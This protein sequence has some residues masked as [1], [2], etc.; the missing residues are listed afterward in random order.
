MSVNFILPDLTVTGLLTEV[1]GQFFQGAV[2]PT[3]EDM[4]YQLVLNADV[5]YLNQIFL[6]YSDNT[7]GAGE[8]LNDASFS[9]LKY[10]MHVNQWNPEIET[11]KSERKNVIAN[12]LVDIFGGASAASALFN[13]DVFS[14][15][16]ALDVDISDI[17]I[18]RI[19]LQQ[20]TNIMDSSAV[21]GAFVNNVKL[22]DV[23][24]TSPGPNDVSS[25]NLSA[26]TRSLLEQ[27]SIYVQT[28]TT[29]TAFRRQFDTTNTSNTTYDLLPGWRTFQFVEN[30]T[31]KFNVIIRQPTSFYPA[32][33]ANTNAPT[34]GGLDT[35]FAVTITAKNT[36]TTPVAVF[37][38]PPI[39]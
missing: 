17:F 13:I 32:W 33:S 36:P 3:L 4:S 26:I 22:V 29:S 31:I 16:D 19:Q 39:V 21:H 8:D 5:S 25:S 9:D 28:N 30:D 1:S 11:T 27:A 37:T 7:T 10:A 24:N 38:D 14:N 35:R 20:R 15:E 18:N 23:S 2:A 34:T 6:F 12:L